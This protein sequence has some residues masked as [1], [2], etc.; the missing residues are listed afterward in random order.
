M[1]PIQARNNRDYINAPPR[2]NSSSFFSWPPRA[3]GQTPGRVDGQLVAIILG[4]D[5]SRGTANAILVGNT[6]IE[7]RATDRV[8]NG[9]A[10][11]AR[12]PASTPILFAI[13]RTG[14]MQAV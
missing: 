9:L 2:V 3:G 1:E 6:T 8:P 5:D 10:R 12:P 4:G 14:L 11:V 7:D 13:V